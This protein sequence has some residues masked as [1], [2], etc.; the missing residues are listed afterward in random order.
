MEPLLQ[1][2]SK[3]DLLQT[4]KNIMNIRICCVPDIKN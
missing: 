4:D 1:Y 3:E 2:D